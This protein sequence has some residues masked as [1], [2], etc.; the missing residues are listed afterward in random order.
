MREYRD[1]KLEVDKDA[2]LF[3]DRGNHWKD[4]GRREYL[5]QGERSQIKVRGLQKDKEMFIK[6]Y[7]KWRLHIQKVV[8]CFGLV[9]IITLFITRRITGKLY[10]AG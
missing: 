3:D 5:G 6:R 7:F 2:S 4:I 9:W 1:P 8:I 10:C